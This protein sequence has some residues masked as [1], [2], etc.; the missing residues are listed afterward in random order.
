MEMCEICWDET[1]DPRSIKG[2]ALRKFIASRELKP[3]TR[4]KAIYQPVEKVDL[5]DADKEYIKNH[6]DKLTYVEMTR[7][8]FNDDKITNLD[9]RAIQVQEH[10]HKIHEESIFR[11]Q[12]GF[13]QV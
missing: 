10:C 1:I 3:R 4:M 6:I 8:I 11:G 5:T 13:I 12:Q 2:L 9:R 7:T